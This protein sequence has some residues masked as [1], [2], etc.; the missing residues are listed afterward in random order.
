MSFVRDTARR[1]I[2]PL[3]P[4]KWKRYIKAEL[5]QVPGHRELVTSD[6]EAGIQSGSCHRC[7]AHIWESGPAPSSRFSQIREC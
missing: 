5:L 3:L 7:R 1:V 4:E 6:E 2:S